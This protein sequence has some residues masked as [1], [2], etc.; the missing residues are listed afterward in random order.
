MDCFIRNSTKLLFCA[1][2]IY[3]ENHQLYKQLKFMVIATI[4]IG[5]VMEEGGFNRIKALKNKCQYLS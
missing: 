2:T 1:E 3:R 5:Y 4:Y